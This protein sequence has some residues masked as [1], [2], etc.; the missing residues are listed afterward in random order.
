VKNWLT[1]ATKK[2]I[3]QEIKKILYDH[4]RYRNDSNNVQAQYAFTQRPSRGVIID[5]T[6]ADRIR[7][8]ADNYVGRL[9]SFCMLAPVDC[10]PGTS[11]EWVRENFNILEQVKP[12][13]SVFPT[14]AGV[15]IVNIGTIPDDARQ[16]PGSFTVEP[17]LTVTNE[18]VII[19]GSSAVTD[20]QLSHDGIYPGSCRL[21]INRRRVLIPDVDYHIDDSSGHITFLRTTPAG[22]PVHADYRYVMPTQGPFPFQSLSTDVT[23]IPGAVLAFGDRVQDC[24]E[25]AVV[26]TQDRTEV[27]EIY[28]G[29]FE[30]TFSIIAFTRDSEDRERMSDYIIGKILERQNSIGFEGLELLDVSPGGENQEVYNAETDEYYYESQIALTLR[31]DWEIQLP[32]PVVVNRAEM[33]SKVMEMSN[34]YLD[35][36]YALD[37]LQ[38][39]SQTGVTAVPVTIGRT[40]TY[41]RVI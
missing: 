21:W 6:T 38:I 5:N 41:E 2:R 3:I 9:S 4:P 7:L 25:M 11:L 19:F 18:P 29:K 30:V 32:L 22:D 17:I 33:T 13:R 23:A 37:L 27:A 39:Y 16:I 15:Y 36:S 26:I 12:D 35:G 14:P 8:Q 1:N 31:V 24:D 34:G 10:K 28:G 40:L 20:A